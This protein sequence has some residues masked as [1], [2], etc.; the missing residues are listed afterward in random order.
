MLKKIIVIIN[1]EEHILR[2]KAENAEEALIE[3]KIFLRCGPWYIANN[4][5]DI[6]KEIKTKKREFRFISTSRL[7]NW[8]EH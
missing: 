2:T 7:Y 6:L 5:Y 3:A 4:N 8:V 1:D